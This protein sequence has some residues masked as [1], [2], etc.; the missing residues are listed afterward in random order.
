[1]KKTFLTFALAIS[2]LSFANEA[3]CN[4]SS[5][6]SNT[7]IKTTV[8]VSNTKID[9]AAND[10]MSLCTI[11]ITET[12]HFGMVVNQWQESYYVPDWDFAACK[13]IGD[14]RVAQLNSGL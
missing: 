10:M 5:V 12:N 4:D 14:M 11:T 7:S 2:A 3:N 1:M 13:A 8:A 9:K 6:D